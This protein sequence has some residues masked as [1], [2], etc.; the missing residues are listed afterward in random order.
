[1]T[2]AMMG[3]HSS[4]RSAHD[5]NVPHSDGVDNTNDIALQSTCRLH[6]LSLQDKF[7]TSKSSSE[8]QVR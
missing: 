1:M 5:R 6:L 4:K 7:V 2:L 3:G 8:L